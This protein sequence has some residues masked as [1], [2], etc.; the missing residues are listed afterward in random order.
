M[1]KIQYGYE[2][3]L[4]LVTADK[5]WSGASIRAAISTLICREPDVTL[6]ILLKF[7]R[8]IWHFVL[9]WFCFVG[10]FFFLIFHRLTER[11]E[12]GKEIL[13]VLTMR[14]LLHLQRGSG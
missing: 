14:L 4:L 7:S 12:E 9:F 3:G 11:Y 6:C 2:I 8:N 1:S 5:S 13:P 10:F